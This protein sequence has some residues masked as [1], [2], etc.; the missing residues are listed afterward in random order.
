MRHEHLKLILLLT[1]F[2]M[3]LG[4]GQVLAADPPG[5]PTTDPNKRVDGNHVYWLVKVKG[6]GVVN[7]CGCN[8]ANGCTQIWVKNRT[9]CTLGAKPPASQQFSHWTWRGKF[10]GNGSLARLTVLT[11]GTVEAHFR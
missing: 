8:T 10:H 11:P 6:P 7:A 4:G 1:A 3:A 2:L 9:V 5:K